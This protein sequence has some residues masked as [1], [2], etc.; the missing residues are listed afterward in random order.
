MTPE[1]LLAAVLGIQGQGVGEQGWGGGDK[2]CMVKEERKEE[3]KSRD[4]CGSIS[5]K[6]NLMF[7]F[8]PCSLP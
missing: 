8:W 5:L 3:Q 4:Q 7:T 1:V 6:P 2:G